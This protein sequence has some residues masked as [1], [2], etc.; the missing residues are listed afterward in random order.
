MLG[1]TELQIP[2]RAASRCALAQL[3]VRCTPLTLRPPANR[4]REKLALAEVFA[5][6]VLEVEIND[7][8]DP[9]EWLLGCSMPTRTNEQA[10]ERL[11]WYA[12]RWTIES[13]HRVLKSG[14]RIE[15]H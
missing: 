5:I 8:V 3:Q 9:L 12:R 6:H 15:A 10:L 4:Q 13:W 1:K 11:G 7:S 14:C 2:A